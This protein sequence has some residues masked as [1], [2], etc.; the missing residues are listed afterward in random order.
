[1]I[2]FSPPRIDQAS[3]DAVS[4][5]LR[6]GWITTG[7]KTKEFERQL[8][9][10]T[11][12]G[13]VF[14]CNSNTNGME[15][16]L[17]WLGIGPGDE[18]IVPAYTYCA[19]ANVV[20]HLGATPVM[21]DVL[22]DFTIDPQGVAAAVT[23]QTKAIIPV[24]LAGLP[25]HY[26]QLWE[27]IQDKKSL[28]SPNSESQNQF[29]RIALV[30]DSAHSIGARYK[31]EILGSQAD[32]MVFSFHAVKNLTTAEGGG[33][34]FNLG[35]EFNV[36]EVYTWLN[37][38]SL[39][40]QSKDA[41]A[42][43]AAGNWEYDVVEAGWKCNMTDLQAALGLVELHRYHD[44]TL[45]KRKAIALAYQDAFSVNPHVREPLLADSERESSYHIYPIR[46]ACEDRAKRDE[47]IKRIMARDVSVNVHYKPLPLLSA[48]SSSYSI[49]DYPKTKLIWQQ[50]ISLPIYYD[51]SDSDLERVIEAVELS[52]DEV[53]T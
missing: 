36:E 46:I 4:E 33:I 3:I 51:L 24:D 18:V 16:F 48:Y 27:I 47:V 34:C 32:A 53:L 6:S 43:T 40:G 21:V 39:H 50:E 52:V 8:A 26:D 15:L 1:M 28:Y 5:V 37:T 45:P 12:A 49:E 30:S 31:D 7:P 42:K 44:E 23:G 13:R 22:D 11:G 9:A 14:C 20:M 17:R 2:P 41:L 10:Y 35:D 19:T 29:G 38:R 25:V